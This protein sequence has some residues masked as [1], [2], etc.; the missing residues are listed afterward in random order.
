MKEYSDELLQ[1]HQCSIGDLIDLNIAPISQAHN[2][3]CDISN[4]TRR[5]SQVIVK[6]I[7]RSYLDEGC[8]VVD[9]I[10]LM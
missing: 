7:E 2:L 8:W 6:D 5:P 4:W 3:Q 9:R 1:E 10:L